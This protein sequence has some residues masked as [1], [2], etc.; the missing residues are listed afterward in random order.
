MTAAR[1]KAFVDE[2]PDNA[3]SK[4]VGHTQVNRYGFAK[5]NVLTEECLLVEEDVDKPACTE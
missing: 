4:A 5:C 3:E 2:L 1:A